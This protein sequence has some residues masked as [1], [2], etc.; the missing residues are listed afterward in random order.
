M[1]FG[2]HICDKIGRCYCKEHR[3][4]VCHECCLA[5]DVSNRYAEEAA[6]LRKKRT[7]VEEAAEEKAIVMFA[8]RGMERMRPRPSDAVFAEHRELSRQADKKLRTF[9]RADV[10]AAMKKAIDEQAR[11]EIDRNALFQAWA[12][13][14]PGETHF[15]MGGRQT[16]D[17]YDKVVAKPTAKDTRA[18]NFTCAY[19]HK[20]STKKLLCCARCKTVS[21]CGKD[22]QKAAWKAHKT[23]CVKWDKEKEP[24]TLCL[25]WDQVE[26]H[27]GAPVLRRTLEV[28]AMLDES[29]TRQVFQCKDRV[30]TIRRVAAYT[31]SRKIPGLKPGALLQWKNPRFHYF[32]DGSSGA[33]IEEDDLEN[34]TIA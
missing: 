10:E 27:D 14:H 33:R 11:S 15:E 13:E 8:L 19:C 28:R 7:P 4:E 21:Y 3:R 32:M 22:C 24:K 26:A 17:L 31:N 5:F 29:V 12:A 25:T 18:E 30:G 16:Q 1:P 6:G 2:E 9:P 34:I 20:T 23:Q